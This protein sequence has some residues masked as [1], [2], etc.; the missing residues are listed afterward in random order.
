MFLFTLI[1]TQVFTTNFLVRPELKRYLKN[2]LPIRLEEII[3]QDTFDEFEE[4][5]FE[6]EKAVLMNSIATKFTFLNDQ[7]MESQS[8]LWKKEGKIEF[9]YQLFISG[10]MGNQ[11]WKKHLDKKLHR[12]FKKILKNYNR[13]LKIVGSGE[14]ELP[15]YTLKT[16]RRYQI[17]GVP[18]FI[19]EVQKFTGGCI[20]LGSM[21][22]EY[23][24]ELNNQNWAKH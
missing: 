18:E 4:I 10:Y 24:L 13:E 2:D 3:G 17:E 1:L 22:I 23:K 12:D 7:Q 8:Y 9:S 16:F 14:E 15:G 11:P 6:E 5:E 19:I 21:M 20:K